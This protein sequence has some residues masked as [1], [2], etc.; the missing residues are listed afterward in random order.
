MKQ[1][2]KKL[3]IF[4]YVLVWLIIT[5][6][7]IKYTFVAGMVF[8]YGVWRIVVPL[9]LTLI[10]FVPVVKTLKEEIK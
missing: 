9:I 3:S 4:I 6:Y 10:Y 1:F 7:G 8:F 5:Y 2:L